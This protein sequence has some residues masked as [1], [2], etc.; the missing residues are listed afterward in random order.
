MLWLRK[1][2]KYISND[3]YRIRVNL[4]LG[5]YNNLEDIEFIKLLFKALMGYKL[6]IEDPKTFNEKLQWLKL[7]DRKPE[8]TVMVDKYKVRDYIAEKIG[9]KYLIPLLGVW[10]DPDDID[11]DLLP[12]QFVLKCNHNSGGIFICKNKNNFDVV[13]VKK[14]LKKGLKRDYYLSGRE[15]PYKDVPRK[16]I[17]EK[18]MTDETGTNLRDYKFY[19]FDGKAKVVGIYQDRNTGKETTGDFFDMDFNWLDFTFNMPNAK[20][21]PS[22]PNH[23]E[24]MKEIAEILSKGIPHVRVDLYLS[25]DRIYFGELTFFDGSGFDKIEPFEW[26]VKLGSWINLPDKTY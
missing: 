21:K 20:V 13:K 7:Y 4:T 2:F 22:K 14:E 10:D 15:W 6:P 1:I 26:D 18:Y 24:K 3:E 5:L 9:D 12:N 17:A 23:F 11:F 25:N 16:I 19:C 8:Y